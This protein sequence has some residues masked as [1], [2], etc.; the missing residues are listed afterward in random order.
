MARVLLYQHVPESFRRDLDLLGH[1]TMTVRYMGWG[2]IENG[3]LLRRADLE[4]DALVTNDLEFR[5]APGHQAAVR[6]CARL[7][8]VLVR[9]HPF[10]LEALRLL[11]TAIDREIR[12]LSPGRLREVPEAR[13]LR[14]PGERG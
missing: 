5:D 12:S 11:A 8:V 14:R 4:F 3:E 13:P 1:E 9:P 10:R 6:A 2:G 7:G